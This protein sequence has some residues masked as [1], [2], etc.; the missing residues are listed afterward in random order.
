MRF[1]LSDMRRRCRGEDAKAHV[2]CGLLIRGLVVARDDESPRVLAINLRQ[3]SNRSVSLTLG[4]KANG[5][6]AVQMLA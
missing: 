4:A 2:G 3:P 6:R 5:E 1:E